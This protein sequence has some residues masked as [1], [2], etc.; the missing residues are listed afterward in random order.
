M[1]GSCDR[2]SGT[3]PGNSKEGRGT[4]AEAV[5]GPWGTAPELPTHKRIRYPMDRAC[6]P[7]PRSA[8]SARR[9]RCSAC[10]ATTSPRSS[11]ASR[12]GAV[13]Y[14]HRAPRTRGV[15]GLRRPDARLRALP[16]RRL[17]L[18]PVPFSCT[19][20]GFCLTCGGTPRSAEASRAQPAASSHANRLSIRASCPSFRERPPLTRSGSSGVAPSSSGSTARTIQLQPNRSASA[21]DDPTP[22]RGSGAA[23][24]PA[25]PARRADADPAWPTS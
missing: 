4:S 13:A 19:G 5:I 14:R 21:R 11:S 3:G 10:S 25:S 17:R 15:P 8:A 22:P 12:P 6:R 16:L 2:V 9:P 18:R 7:T 23:G 20:R 1:A 24:R